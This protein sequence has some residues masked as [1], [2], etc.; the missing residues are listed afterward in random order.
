MF[1]HF[2]NKMKLDFLSTIDGFTRLEL[3]IIALS[4]TIILCSGFMVYSVILGVILGIFVLIWIKSIISD[5]LQKR[6]TK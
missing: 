3:Q 5:E 2:I 4:V 6:N 1:K